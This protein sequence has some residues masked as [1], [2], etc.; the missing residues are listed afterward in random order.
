MAQALAA[1]AIELIRLASDYAKRA[2]QSGELTPEQESALDAEFDKMVVEYA[3][4]PPP[5]EG[6]PV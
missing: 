5:P 1:V 6:H 2:K 3:D 4:A